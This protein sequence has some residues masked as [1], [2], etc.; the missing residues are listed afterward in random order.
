MLPTSLRVGLSRNAT[1]RGSRGSRAAPEDRLGVLPG[2]SRRWGRCD[3][4]TGRRYSCD[5]AA[6]SKVRDRLSHFSTAAVTPFTF[7]SECDYV[8]RV[9]RGRIRRRQRA[10]GL[11]ILAGF[12]CFVPREGH[13]AMT[14]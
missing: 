12:A 11:V 7:D 8:Q 6:I 2:R 1:L 13:T 4:M 3:G 10:L 5:P 9:H 14:P